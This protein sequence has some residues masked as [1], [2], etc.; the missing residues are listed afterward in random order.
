[1]NQRIW[2]PVDVN[3]LLDHIN[4][5]KTLEEISKKERRPISSIQ[6]K[7]KEIAADLYFNKNMKYDRVQEITGIPK[8]A[9]LVK[10]RAVIPERCGSPKEAEITAVIAVEKAL[11]EVA[12]ETIQ[13]NSGYD[14]R[15]S[16]ENPFSISSLSALIHTTVDI[17]LSPR[18]S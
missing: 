10:R 7:L 9:L 2:T 3:R 11:E 13:S 18:N 17:C 14:I 4:K 12:I 16:I 5:N 1:M 15:L 8:E 6:T